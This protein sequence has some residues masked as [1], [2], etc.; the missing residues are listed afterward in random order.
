V[1]TNVEATPCRDAARLPGLLEQQVTAAV[2]F[3]EMVEALCA[4]G[5][6][7]VLE[8]GPGRVLTGLVARISRGLARASLG[9]AKELEPAADFAVGKR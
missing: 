9:I 6:D 2:R 8:V 3:T 5:V 1:V 4:A 7:R